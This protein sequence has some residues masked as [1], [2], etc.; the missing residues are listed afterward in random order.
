VMRATASDGR[1]HAKKAKEAKEAVSCGFWLR[2]KGAWLRKKFL[3]T[4]GGGA[5]GGLRFMVRQLN[6]LEIEMDQAARAA[7]A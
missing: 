6:G 7:E 5:A 3:V 1:V 4:I 2:K